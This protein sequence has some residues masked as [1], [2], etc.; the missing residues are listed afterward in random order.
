ME[1]LAFISHILLAHTF[2]KCLACLCKQPKISIFRGRNFF[3]GGNLN[4]SM[5]LFGLPLLLKNYM[6]KMQGHKILKG[7]IN[8]D[9][10][11]KGSGKWAQKD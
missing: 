1:D 11:H 4:N 3:L 8:N 9:N 10:V 2:L 7:E 5:M 6:W